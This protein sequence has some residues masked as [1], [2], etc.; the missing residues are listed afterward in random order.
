MPLNITDY[1]TSKLSFIAAHKKDNLYIVNY[2]FVQAHIL[3]DPINFHNHKTIFKI[4]RQYSNKK[5]YF[6]QSTPED[7]KQSTQEDKKQSTQ[8]DKNQSTPEDKN[9]S[10]QEGKKQSMQEGK[11]QSTQEDNNQITYINNYTNFI[12]FINKI[13]LILKED[14][15]KKHISG[16]NPS[17]SSSAELVLTVKT[18][19]LNNING[20]ITN[21]S[22]KYSISVDELKYILR[23]EIVCRLEVCPEYFYMGYKKDGSENFRLGVTLKSI[24]IENDQLNKLPKRIEI[25]IKYSENKDKIDEI[26]QLDVLYNTPIL[27]KYISKKSI[28]N[29]IVNTHT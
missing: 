20:A 28:V 22:V 26:K 12:N 23:S 5:I 27:P 18:N 3:S 4:N 6:K 1:D 15:V 29:R 10:M 9:Q 17:T 24:H 19:K 25:M 8:E 7:K 13:K 2:N 21:G 11:N 14:F 16:K